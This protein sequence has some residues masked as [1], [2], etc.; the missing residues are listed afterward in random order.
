MHGYSCSFYFSLSLFNIYKTSY[1][2]NIFY[3]RV[4]ELNLNCII[5]YGQLKFNKI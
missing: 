5:N 3:M 2:K 4:N 1:E